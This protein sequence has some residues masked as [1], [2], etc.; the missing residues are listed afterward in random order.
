MYIIYIHIYQLTLMEKHHAQELTVFPKI[1][2]APD[3]SDALILS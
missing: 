2:N 3:N 1:K